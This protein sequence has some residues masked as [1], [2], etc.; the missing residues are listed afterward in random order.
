MG[1]A[2]VKRSKKK[3]DSTGLTRDDLL[4]LY[5]IMYA[6]R[7]TDDKEIVLKRQNRAYFQINGA[8]HEAICAAAGYAAKSGHDWFYTYYRDRALALALGVTPY[9]MLLQAVGAADDPASAAWAP[10]AAPRRSRRC[11]TTETS[12]KR[13]TAT[14][15]RTRSSW[16][17]AATAARARASSGRR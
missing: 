5:R 12:G 1:N 14:S 17:P 3:T 4:A 6:S 10:S 15:S 13:W 8:G 9:E 7:K 16:R 11:A 2:R